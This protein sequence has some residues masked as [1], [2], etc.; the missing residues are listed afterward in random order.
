MLA[1]G[2]VNRAA[3]LARLL[4]G[5]GLE[6]GSD[7]LI[8][9]WVETEY[10]PDVPIDRA[11][12]AKPHLRRLLGLRQIPC[13]FLATEPLQLPKGVRPCLSQ[14][15]PTRPALPCTTCCGSPASWTTASRRRQPGRSCS[16]GLTG[17]RCSSASTPAASRPATTTR[18]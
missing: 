4:A 12:D 16:T 14:A 15:G 1:H 8:S 18:P 7:D 17:R 13:Q 6:R 5:P 9:A 10:H 3:L 11:A 2:Q